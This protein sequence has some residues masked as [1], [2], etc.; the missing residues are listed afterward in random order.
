[1]NQFD[2]LL[3]KTWE[4]EQQQVLNDF[5]AESIESLHSYLQS[6]DMIQQAS[7]DNV[8]L[9]GRPMNFTQIDDQIKQAESN[10]YA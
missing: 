5:A 9:H 7:E 2:S 8:V 4:Y 6:I 10:T 1:M 3:L